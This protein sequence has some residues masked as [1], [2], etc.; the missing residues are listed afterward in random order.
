MN[1]RSFILGAT[2]LGVLSA[3][4]TRHWF[5]AAQGQLLAGACSDSQNNHYVGA[6]DQSGK[7]ICQ[8]PIAARGHGVIDH[9]NKPGHGLVIGRSPG[10]VAYEVDFI[11]GSIRAQLSPA[12]DHHFYGHGQ[13]SPDGQYFITTEQNVTT[14]QGLIVIRE[15]QHYQVV[16]QYDSGGIGPHEALFL[17]DGHTLVI[18]NGGILTH[19]DKPKAKLNLDTMAPNLSYMDIRSG[20]IINSTTPSHHQLSIRHLAIDSSGKVYGGMQYQGANTELLPLAFSHQ[21]AGPL[22]PLNATAAL[23]RQ[24]QQYTASLCVDNASKTLAISCPRSDMITFW[25]I[26]TDSFISQVQLRDGAGLARASSGI[27]ATSGKGKAW[28]GDKS[29]QVFSNIRWDNHLAL[30]SS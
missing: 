26:T 7:L 2:A 17:P 13:F 12:Q 29:E 30:I 9:P 27:V 8:V 24:M 10:Y 19:P 15:S 14:G 4:G 25:D 21:G 3:F 18:A 1:R 11:Q 22:Q 28:F 23:W 6:F 16:A 5:K 20:E